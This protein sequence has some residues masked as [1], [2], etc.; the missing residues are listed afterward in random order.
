LSFWCRAFT[1]LQDSSV[2]VEARILKLANAVGGLPG[3][4]EMTK[5]LIPPDIAVLH[6]S[7]RISM[8]KPCQELDAQVDELIREKIVKI[9]LDLAHV[10]RVDSTGFGTIVMSSG[11]VKKLGGELRVAGASG[12]VAE[13]AHSSQIPRIVPFHAKVEEALTNFAAV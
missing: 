3:M 2:T 12:I 7:G 6:L 5:E 1:A 13:I 9:V 10:D 4:F 11:K 8:G